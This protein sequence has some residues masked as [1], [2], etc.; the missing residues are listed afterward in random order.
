MNY[1]YNFIIHPISYTL[2]LTI[3]IFYRLYHISGLLLIALNLKSLLFII[4]VFKRQRN[5]IKNIFCER[6]PF[7]TLLKR[8]A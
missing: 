7:Y 3:V 5:K 4:I 1:E 2:D 8:S 6:A